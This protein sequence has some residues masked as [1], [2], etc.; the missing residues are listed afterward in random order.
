MKNFTELLEELREARQISKKDLAI[1]AGLTP[2]YV[3]LLTRGERTAP[4]QETVKALAD[5]LNLDIEAKTTFFKAAGYSTTPISRNSYPSLQQMGGDIQRSGTTR[6]DW[7]EVPDVGIFYGRQ[8][9]QATLEHWTL[10]DRCRVVAVL[11]IGG[12]GKTSLAA[13]LA[14]QI[15]DRF[16]YVFWRSLQD[17]PP[18]E[19]IFIE[20][21]QFL[22]DQRPIHLP[23]E[24]EN[25]LPFLLE[26]FLESLR[27]RHC[28]IVLDNFEAVLLSGEHAGEYRER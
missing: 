23:E 9:E 19:S 8:E 7:G 5:A 27:N 25:R 28:L 26:L 17:A 13:T 4:S 15:K 11:G 16:E 2:G 10:D 3:S 20:C 22:S 18:L 14:M 6:V 24:E 12:I 1:R 21:I